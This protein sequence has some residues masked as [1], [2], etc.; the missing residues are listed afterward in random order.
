MPLLFFWCDTL[1]RD[2]FH[3]T[4]IQIKNFKSGLPARERFQLIGVITAC[5]IVLFVCFFLSSVG[6]FSSNIQ[7]CYCSANDH[8]VHPEFRG[9]YLAFT[10]QVFMFFQSWLLKFFFLEEY[11]DFHLSMP[12]QMLSLHLNI[13]FSDLR[14]LSCHYFCFPG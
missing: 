12:Y 8:T 14:W 1:F 4:L 2:L 6:L 10:L 11:K 13:D 5:L 9:G 3:A 7:C